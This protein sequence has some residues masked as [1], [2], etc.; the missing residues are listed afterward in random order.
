MKSKIS[1][2]HF[3]FCHSALT[4]Q[5]K[6]EVVQN[7]T[8]A[9]EILPKRFRNIVT[10]SF[11]VDENLD[12]IPKDVVDF[13]RKFGKIGIQD[14]PRPTLQDTLSKIESL[15]LVYSTEYNRVISPIFSSLCIY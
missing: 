3:V 9:L 10:V 4:C 8:A 15:D 7:I 12:P 11:Y 13:G 1:P 2:Q 5:N 14:Y 6:I